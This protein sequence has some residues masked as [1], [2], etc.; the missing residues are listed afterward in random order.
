MKIKYIGPSKIGVEIL[1]T[2]Q[3]VASGKTI[4]VSEELGTS[5]CEQ[6]TNWKKVTNSTVETTTDVTE[7]GQAK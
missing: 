4:E 2:T 7:E 3:H 5:L 6:K 1:S